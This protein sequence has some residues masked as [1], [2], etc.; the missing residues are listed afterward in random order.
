MPPIDSPTAWG[1]NSNTHLPR[2]LA[3]GGRAIVESGAGSPLRIDSLERLRQRRYGAA[4]VSFYGEARLMSERNGTVVC[5]GS[6]DPVTNG[7]LDIITRT[8]A[9]LRAGRRR[10]RQ[11]PGPQGEDAVHRRGAPGLHR[12][13]DRR[14]CP[15]SRSQIFSNLLVE[16]ARDNGAKAIVKGLRAISD[17]EYEFEMA[18]LNRKLDPGIES[19]YVIASPHYSF[20]SSTGVKEMAT[21]GGDVSDLVPGP[22]RGRDGGAPG[23]QVGFPARS[24]RGRELAKSRGNNGFFTKDAADT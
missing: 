22:G 21:F 10:R 3:E 14:A 18:Q 8:S 2:L 20:L 1:R 6:Y 15:T 17:F 19:I 5:P 9:G 23:R 11:Q 4:D 16:F 13:G 7:H 12:G 24:G